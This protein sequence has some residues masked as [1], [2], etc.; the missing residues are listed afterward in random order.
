MN[1]AEGAEPSREGPDPH[2]I[3]SMFASI[4]PRYDLLNHL[5]SLSVDRLWR[6]R[7]V[8]LISRHAPAEGDRCLDLCTGTGDLALDVTR[9]LGVP[10]TGLDFCHPMLVRLAAKKRDN[11]RVHLT[12]S[13]AQQLPFRESS[14]RFVTIA[15]GLRNVAD[16]QTAL[17]EIRRV[18]Q[19]GGLLVILEFSQPVVPIVRP[20]FDVYFHRVL[21]AIGKWISG[22]DG[23]YAYLPASV[24]RFPDQRRLAGELEAAGFENVAFRNLTTGIAALHWGT[25][26]S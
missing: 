20:L 18:L 8:A 7:V 13:D 2:E 1:R 16:R 22:R 21:P 14:F 15:F 17:G 11:D 5:L 23:P 19:P 12:E 9:R 3:R 4:A 10:A 26:P 25:K 6:R 24:R